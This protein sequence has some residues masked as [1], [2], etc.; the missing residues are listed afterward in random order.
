MVFVVVADAATVA[1]PLKRLEWA[2]VTV[3]GE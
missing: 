3:V 1:D 2:E